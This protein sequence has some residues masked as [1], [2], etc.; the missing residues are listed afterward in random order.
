MLTTFNGS[1]LAHVMALR[2]RYRDVFGRSTAC[3]SAMSFFVRLRAGAQEV[4]P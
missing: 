3:G 2:S 4:R 1:T